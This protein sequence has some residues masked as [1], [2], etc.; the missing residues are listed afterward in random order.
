MLEIALP[1]SL[2]NL[3][4]SVH[5]AHSFLKVHPFQGLSPLVDRVLGSAP[6]GSPAS[7]QQGTQAGAQPRS[8]TEGPC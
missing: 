7:A 2:G 3:S 1:R 5:L 6:I 8:L 4:G